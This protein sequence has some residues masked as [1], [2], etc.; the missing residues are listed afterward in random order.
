MA[1]QEIRPYRIQSK[2]LAHC[3][4]GTMAALMECRGNREKEQIG[5]GQESGERTLSG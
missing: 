2:W 1:G 5:N 3:L 4:C